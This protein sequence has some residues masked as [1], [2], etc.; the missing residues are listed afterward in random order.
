[1]LKINQNIFINAD[2]NTIWAYLTDFSLSLRF[3]R[4]HVNLELPQKRKVLFYCVMDVIK[5]I[6]RIASNLPLLMYLKAI[7]TATSVSI[8]QQ[9]L[10]IV[11]FVERKAEKILYP[12]QLVQGHT[13]PTAYRHHYQRLVQNVQSIL[14]HY[15]NIEL[16]KYYIIYSCSYQAT[17]YNYEVELQSYS[18]DF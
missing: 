15:K 14:Q 5:V 8:R 1:M 18:M 9:V 7:G 4:F 3:N 17:T 10:N 16:D 13:T 11:W 6:I 12:A 2:V